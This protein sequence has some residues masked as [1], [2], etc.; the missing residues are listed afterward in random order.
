MPYF[1]E[2]SQP[3]VAEHW[4][5]SIEKIFRTIRCEEDEKVN[6]TTF[7][8]EER[9]DVWWSAVLRNIYEDG[10]VEV[11]WGDFI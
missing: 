4:L 5:R 10:T 11:T 8:L 3:I 9:T 1:K 7:M 6:L 2:E